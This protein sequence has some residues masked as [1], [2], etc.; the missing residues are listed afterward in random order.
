MRIGTENAVLRFKFGEEK[1]LRLIAEA[2]FECVDYSL[3]NELGKSPDWLLADDYLESAEK[4]RRLIEKT[5]W[6]AVRLMCRSVCRPMLRAMRAIRI[7]WVYC[8]VWNT[9]V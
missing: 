1:S 2:G 3:F 7:I 6:C 8:A 9:P 5:V 4:T